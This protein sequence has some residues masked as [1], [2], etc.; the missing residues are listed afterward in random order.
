MTVEAPAWAGSLAPQG[1]VAEAAESAE[2]HREVNSGERSQNGVSNA[3]R[4]A[5]RN[6]PPTPHRNIIRTVRDIAHDIHHGD[7]RGV[8]QFLRDGLI[9]GSTANGSPTTPEEEDR[10]AIDRVLPIPQH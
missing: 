3:A 4:R 7:W 6:L 8:G 1:I 2:D 5:F 9:P 10:A